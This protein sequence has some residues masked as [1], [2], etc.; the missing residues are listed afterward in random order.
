MSSSNSSQPARVGL[1]DNYFSIDDILASQERV[2]CKF[3]VVVINMGHLDPGS[4]SPHLQP[5]T[6][7]ELPL[8]LA[9]TVCT[10]NHR[11]A[12][13]ELPKSYRAGH[14]EILSADASVVDLR[15]Y[16]AYYYNVGSW[17]LTFDLPE[18][19]DVARSLLQTFQTRLRRIMDASQNSLDADSL[20]LVETLDEAERAIFAAGQ[21][22]L[23]EFLMW[24]TRQSERL[25]SSNMVANLKKRK[26]IQMEDC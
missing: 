23:S 17:L 10:G 2:L 3:E 24:E 19:P 16:S 20:A 18:V 21:Q 11:I 5:G 6:Q 7:L 13:V 22:G 25:V 9:R 26:R 1:Q 4:E 12:S 8:W 15:R 14:R